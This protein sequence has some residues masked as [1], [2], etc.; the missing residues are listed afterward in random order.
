MCCGRVRFC[1]MLACEK[2]AH[3]SIGQRLRHT[4]TIAAIQ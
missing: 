2:Q 1:G 4:A 3:A